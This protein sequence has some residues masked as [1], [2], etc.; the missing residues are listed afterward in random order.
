MSFSRPSLTELHARTRSDVTTRV[1]GAAPVLRRGILT[2]LITAL[3][4]ALH[5]LYGFLQRRAEAAVP[6]T[7]RGDDLDRWASLWGITRREATRAAGTITVTGAPGSSIATGAKLQSAAGQVYTVDAGDDIGGGGSVDLDVTAEQPGSAGN[8]LAGAALAFISPPAGVDSVATVAAGALAGATDTETEAALL[9]RL[10]SRIQNPPHGG[11]KGDYERWALAI[12]SI[13]RAW[14][15]PAWRG[16]GSVRVYVVDDNY[17][18][19]E[20]AAPADVTAAFD[21]IN[22]RVPVGMVIEDPE[23][24]GEHINGLEVMSPTPVAV[25][26]SINDIPD[27][28]AARVRVQAALEQVFKAAAVPGATIP[29]NRFIVAIGAGTGLVDFTMSVPATAPEADDDEILVMG[30]ITW[31]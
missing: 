23:N 30:E 27:D 17:T 22:A 15:M 18:G 26:F 2:S 14:C 21:Y 29:L 7:A 16:P 5:L 12:P 11:N 24:P 6:I 3:S 10:L 19:A 25:D 31:T 4:G 9:Q 28:A 13:T 20:T 8:Q 1:Q